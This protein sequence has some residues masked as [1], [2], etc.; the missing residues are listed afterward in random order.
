MLQI[1]Q[2][3]NYQIG[4]R[5]SRDKLVAALTPGWYLAKTIVGERIDIV[6]EKDVFVAHRELEE[7]VKSGLLADYVDVVDLKDDQR[8]L[9]WIDGR[10]AAILTPG[11]TAVWKRFRD[12]RIERL[13]VTDPRFE[14]AQLFAISKWPAADRVLET[15]LVEPGE[16]CLYFKDNRFV[17]Q[18]APGYY[19]FWKGLAGLKFVRVDLR[20]KMLDLAGQEI[21]TSDKVTLRMNAV[22]TYKVV[23]AI[24]SVQV[25]ES[26][27]QALYREAQLILRAAVGSRQLDALLADKDALAGSLVQSVQAKAE[28][29]GLAVV[30]FGIRDIIL[31]GDMRELLNKVVEAQKAAE[32]NQIARREETA[33]T[34]SQCNTAKMLEN[35]PTLMRLRELE[36]L[37]RIAEKSNL[38]IVLGEKSLSERLVNLV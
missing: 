34:R 30:S 33:A 16:T 24:K 22:V 38:R 25:A 5:F 13:T 10:F 32:A 29:F 18:F 8:A 9:L 19:A 15:V 36:V 12:V 20:E 35:N 31:P 3:K 11:R 7:I 6:S 37:E 23:D 2:V 26:P 14:H 17:E 21:M 4:L 28:K 27:E 1:V